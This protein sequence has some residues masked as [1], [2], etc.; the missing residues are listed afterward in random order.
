MRRIW[1]AALITLIVAATAAIPVA[2]DACEAECEAAMAAASTP[3]DPICSATSPSR[4]LTSIPASCGHDHSASVAPATPASAP[5]VRAATVGFADAV[6]ALV[7]VKPPAVSRRVP[8]ETIRP[9][10]TAGR[11]LSVHLRV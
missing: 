5:Q 1:R 9:P 10:G 3:S 2:A 6:A 7:N 8:L 4:E 11:A